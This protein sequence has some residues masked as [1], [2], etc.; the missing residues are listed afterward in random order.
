MLYNKLS[1]FHY[2]NNVRDCPVQ[3][4]HKSHVLYKSYYI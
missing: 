4:R 2:I 3:S 1:K